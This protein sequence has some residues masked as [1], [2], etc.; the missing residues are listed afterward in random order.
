[1]VRAGLCPDLVDVSDFL[2]TLATLA[3]AELPVGATLDGR[4]FAPQLRGEAGRPREWVYSG[5]RGRSF[6]RDRRWKLTNSGD[7]YDLARDPD[8]SAAIEPARDTTESAA[9]RARLEAYVRAYFPEQRL[10]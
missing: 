8:E 4:S 9:A 3:G 5:H 1:M 7:L 2:P 10:P 6:L